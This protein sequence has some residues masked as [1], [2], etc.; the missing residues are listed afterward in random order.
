M[1]TDAS[2]A[3]PPVLLLDWH[4]TRRLGKPRRTRGSLVACQ[5]TGS[6]PPARAP[7]TVPSA[8]PLS[9][10]QSSPGRGTE[11]TEE[12]PPRRYKRGPRA[13]RSR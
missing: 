7:A 6:L 12:L 5:S 8:A 11:P 13:A 10:G 3:L 4:D 1:T 9:T 2:E